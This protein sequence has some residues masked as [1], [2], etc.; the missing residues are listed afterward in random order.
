MGRRTGGQADP[1]PGG[2]V[3]GDLVAYQPP[4][5]EKGGALLR[6]D[7][8]TGRRSVYERHPAATSEREGELLRNAVPYLYRGM[9]FLAAAEIYEWEEGDPETALIAAFR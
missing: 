4:T 5:A 6:F 2:R 9:F 8:A 3:P 7:G 1:A